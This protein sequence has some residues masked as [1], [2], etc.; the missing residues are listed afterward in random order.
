MAA[1]ELESE[2]AMLNAPMVGLSEPP[3]RSITLAE[4]RRPGRR[5]FN[6]PALIELLRHPAAAP[7]DIEPGD[8]VDRPAPPR[9]PVQP[10][11]RHFAITNFDT[12]HPRPGDPRGVSGPVAT[13][14]QVVQV[15]VARAER[16]CRDDR[17]RLEWAALLATEVNKIRGFIAGEDYPTTPPT[18]ASINALIA[19]LVVHSGFLRRLCLISGRDGTPQ[20]NRAVADAIGSLAS[21]TR[22]PGEF[23]YWSELRPLCASLCFYWAVAGALARHDLATVRMFMHT[24]TTRTGGEE[25]LISALP[26]LALGS[27]EWKVLKGLEERRFP[28]SDFLFGLLRTEV[29]E[30]ALD[31]GEAAEDL[32]DRLELLIS[33]EF[34]H[35]RLE[36]IAA[37]HRPLWFWT[38]LGRYVCNLGD[39]LLDRLAALQQ[40]PH[41]DALLQAGL[42]GGTQQTAADAARAMRKSLDT[43]HHTHASGAV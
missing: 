25:A 11:E 38:P 43:C 33:L 6:S 14:Q 42:L 5:L 16:Y 35:R 20:A 40:L 29:A 7:L 2:A 10:D 26:L 4:R 23:S 21:W 28:A 15:A 3:Q 32:C 41:N 13:P 8:E 1:R 9:E 34:S 19:N 12:L 18:G 39:R 36:Q 30:A 24:R 27:I 37:S 17:Y 31:P 22:L